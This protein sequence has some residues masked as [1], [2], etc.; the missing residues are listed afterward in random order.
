MTQTDDK[1][2]LVNIEFFMK[3]CKN[4][5]NK[6]TENLS[7]TARYFFLFWSKFW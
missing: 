7:D 3:A 5:S 2:T 4:L 1:I 6:E